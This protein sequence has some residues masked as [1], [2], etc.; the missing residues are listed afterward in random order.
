MPAVT[1]STPESDMAYMRQSISIATYLAARTTLIYKAIC[2]RQWAKSE[3]D[4]A[5]HYLGHLRNTQRQ[6]LML[7]QAERLPMLAQGGGVGL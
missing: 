5:A 6:L 4:K 2:Y 1:I 3:P 7:R